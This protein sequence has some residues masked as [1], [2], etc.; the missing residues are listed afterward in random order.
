[1][2]MPNADVG[3][4]DPPKTPAFIK[5]NKPTLSQVDIYGPPCP[6]SLP[7]PA[8]SM[9]HLTAVGASTRN[10]PTPNKL[11]SSPLKAADTNDLP[12]FMNFVNR[13]TPSYAGF[14]PFVVEERLTCNG[15]VLDDLPNL[16]PGQ[17]IPGVKL[18]H[19][20]AM[21]H[22]WPAFKHSKKA[23]CKLADELHRMDRGSSSLL[24]RRPST[25]SRMTESCERD[26][27]NARGD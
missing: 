23:R 24:S 10:F 20:M 14:E 15:M 18:G 27:D 19:L 25:T 9:T 26:R 1:M 4:T 6:A 7:T 16:P 21:K 17:E 5:F 12:G 11:P 3:L 8:T 2:T 22:H 13:L